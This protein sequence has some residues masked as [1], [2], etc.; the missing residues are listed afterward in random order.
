MGDEIK[1]QKTEHGI[2]EWYQEIFPAGPSDGFFHK[3]GDHAASFVDRGEHQLVISFDNL[4]DAGYPYTDIR[5]WAESFV[6]GNGWSHLGIYARGPSWYRDAKLIHFL[7]NLRDDE[8]FARFGRVTLIGTSMGGF[9][10]LAFASLVPGAH[11]VAMS[12]QTTLDP[13]IVPWEDRFQ[14]GQAQNWDLPYSD[15][16]TGLE[17]AGKVYVIYDR[18]LE[19]DQAHADRLPQDKII[20]LNAIGCGHKT[21]VALRRMEQ[22][23]P[24]MKLGITGK[25]TEAN[26]YN[27]LRSRRDLLFYRKVME[28][29]LEARNH[30]DRIP[31][32]RQAFKVRRRKVL[33]AA[34]E[35]LSDSVSIDPSPADSRRSAPTPF[36]PPSPQFPP[37]TLD[38][39]RPQNKGNAWMIREEAGAILYMSDQYRG[40]T[41]GFE[42]R[43]GLSLAQTAPLAIG[44]VAFGGSLGTLRD[45]DES[46]LYHV[47]DAELNGHGPLVGARSRAVI[48]MAYD[49]NAGQAHK[50]MLALSHP[51]ASMM[52]SEAEAGSSLYQNMCQELLQARDNLNEWGKRLC[53]DRISLQLLHGELGCSVEAA[54]AHYVK[55]ASSLRRDVTQITGQRSFP[56][57]VII[58]NAGT[59][60]DG[61]VTSALAEA[62]I[63][64][65][66]PTLNFVVATPSYPFDLAEN[67]PA[68]HSAEAQML[69]DEL[70]TCAVREVQNGLA[71]HCP[72][73]VFAQL[74][75][76]RITAEFHTLSAL[77]I[78]EG[79]HGFTL[80]GFPEGTE[81]TAVEARG[82]CVH[83]SL[84]NSPDAVPE[85]RLNYAWG[86]QAKGDEA[87]MANRGGLT[88]SWSA[89]S[90]TY[91]D[92]KLQRYALSG[93]VK[94]FRS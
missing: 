88:D 14:K 72:S 48:E 55:V 43:D 27:M 19:A 53:V 25:L 87:R 52:Q 28:S 9:A 31:G 40:Q 12:P 54:D 82:K 65:D 17:N 73:L 10:A 76:N 63:D 91:P 30:I 21:A 22:L 1:G 71:W 62:R 24:I 56:A 94:V 80:E 46:G 51:Q 18:F 6:R 57:L 5:P 69:M 64:L 42:E 7:E 4:S 81:I 58:Q 78:D 33:A 13:L 20:T 15:A 66:N 85:M 84:S 26:F 29:H 16:A 32:F 39:T 93:S 23:K 44:I 67:M 8:F 3:F 41:M 11:V 86:M 50:T 89:Q 35:Q 83:L 37:D 61:R 59:R 38:R 70:E 34:A 60:Y 90:L 74:S 2:P 49:R 92:M 79:F 45:L 75:G 47:V 77:C 36:A 68:T